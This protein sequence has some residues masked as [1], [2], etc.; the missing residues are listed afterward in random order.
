MCVSKNIRGFGLGTTTYTGR[1][2]GTGSTVIVPTATSV[3]IDI[4]DMDTNETIY[5]YR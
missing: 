4:Y 2:D 3:S 1:E 5:I